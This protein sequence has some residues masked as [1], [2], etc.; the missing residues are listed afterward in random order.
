MKNMGILG[1]LLLIAGVVLFFVER[2]HRGRAT[3]LKAARSVTVA[4]LQS[5]STAIASEIGGGNWRDYIKLT[6]MI[7][8]ER[9]LISELKQEPCVHYQMSVTREYEETVTKQDSQGK[10]YKDTERGSESV[11]SNKRSVPFFLED[12][13]G[14]IEVNPDE[15]NIDT[16]KILDDFRPEQEAGGM[17]SYGGFSL[18]LS[19]SGGN[20]RTLGYRYREAILPVGQRAVVV[21]MMSDH[22]GSLIIQKP[23][24]S[25]RQFIISLKDEENLTKSAESNAKASFYSMVACFG[26]GALLLVIALLT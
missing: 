14:R 16:V 17:I 26:L 6:G 15:A 20:R 3:S 23:T 10:T 12:S 8:C 7:R 9:P 1:V 18:V 22:S 13:T 11:S 25:E 2:F 24:H 19:N 4:E 21:G 5:L